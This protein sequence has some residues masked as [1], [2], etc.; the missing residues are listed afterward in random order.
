MLAPL[1]V[2]CAAVGTYDF[3]ADLGLILARLG[4]YWAHKFGTQFNLMVDD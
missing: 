4:P 1:P 3:G 2:E